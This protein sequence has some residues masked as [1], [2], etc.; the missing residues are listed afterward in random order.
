MMSE[1]DEGNGRLSEGLT[2][3]A[4]RLAGIRGQ[5]YGEHAAGPLTVRAPARATSTSD[6]P[7]PT[8]GCTSPRDRPG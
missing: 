1:T 7:T 3:S 4:L 6:G 8:A 5:H 2:D